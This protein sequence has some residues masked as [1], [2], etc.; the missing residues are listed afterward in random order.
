LSLSHLAKQ[1]YSTRR[2]SSCGIG[3]DSD[4]ICQW[5]ESGDHPGRYR[6]EGRGDEVE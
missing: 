6:G 3:D 2:T 4:Q 1:R 5:R